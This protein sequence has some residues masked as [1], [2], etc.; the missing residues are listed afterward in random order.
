MHGST[1]FSFNN[2][3]SAGAMGRETATHHFPPH[4]IVSVVLSRSQAETV[5][6]SKRS[7]FYSLRR[8]SDHITLSQ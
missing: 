4:Y 2:L 3:S 1:H 5:L 8:L 7:V 6:F